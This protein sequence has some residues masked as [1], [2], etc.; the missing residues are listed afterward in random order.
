[1][2][3]IHTGA[4]AITFPTTPEAFIAYLESGINRKLTDFE[5][6]LSDTV[7]ELA[8]NSY[9]AGVDGDENPLTME[10]VGR[11]YVERGKSIHRFVRMWESICWWCNE[12]YRQ[13]KETRNHE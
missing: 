5:R 10:F 4:A 11:R 3:T 8:N 7:V 2:E 6:K 13:G 9:Q 12:A 1:M